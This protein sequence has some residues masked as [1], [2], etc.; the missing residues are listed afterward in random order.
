M[1]KRRLTQFFSLLALHS[2]WGPELKWLCSPVLSCHSCALSWFACPIGV[3][4]HY[5]GYHLFP[6][7]ALGLVMLLGALMGR[8]LCGWVCPFGFV[9][10]LLHKIPSRKFTLPGWAGWGKYAVLGVMV[11]LLPFLWGESTMASFCRVCPAAAL[12]VTVPGFFSGATILSTL[13]I[14]KL[15]ILAAV[16]VLAVV[17]SRSFCK[18]FCPIGALL[19]PLNYLSFWKVKLPKGG[20]VECG[21]CDR[22]CPVGGEPSSRIH[23]R[24]P[25]NRLGECIVCHDCR[26]ACPLKNR[27]PKSATTPA[28]APGE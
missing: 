12:Q 22:V 23:E 9:Q 5:S 8:F 13:T 10:D 19:A 20:C 25:A 4:V 6:F 27:T 21:Q 3:M 24:T 18:A 11:F 17:S 16:L 7:L 14:V 1:T 26:E 28:P 15:S 2:S